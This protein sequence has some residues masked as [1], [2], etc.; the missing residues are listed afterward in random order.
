ML[1][2]PAPGEW[3]MRTARRAHARL[4]DALGEA[5][6]EAVFSVGVWSGAFVTMAGTAGLAAALAPWRPFRSTHAWVGAPGMALC[7]RMTGTGMRLWVHSAFDPEERG[8]FCQNH[9]SLLDAHVASNAIPHAFCGLMNA[10]QFRIP[11]YGWLMGMSLGIPVPAE[12]QGRTAV[13]AAHARERAALGLSILA[14]PEAHRTR[15]GR[16]HRFHRGVLFMARDAGLPVVPVAVRG[17]REVNGKGRWTFTPGNVE[18]LIGRPRSTAGMGDDAV[19]RLAEDLR[20][21]VASFV[22]DGVLPEGATEV[23]SWRRR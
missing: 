20:L 7:L 1:E 15:D 18:V 22:E 8:V 10:W 23:R 16:V 12:Q 2:Y 11:F 5:A 13:L 6:G 14:F 19:T 21:E 17:L 9:V 4:V 3:A